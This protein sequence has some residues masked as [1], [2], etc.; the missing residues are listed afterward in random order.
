MTTIQF[1]KTGN[2]PYTILTVYSAK[3]Q[4]QV[5]KDLVSWSN[6]Q[7]PVAG[8]WPITISATNPSKNAFDLNNINRSF[9][10]T[11]VIDDSSTSGSTVQHARDTLINMI[12]GGGNCNFSYGISGDATSSGYSPSA[13]NIYF[14]STGF[15]GYITRIM[16]DEVPKGGSSKYSAGTGPDKK[17]PE[18]YEVTI[19]FTQAIEISQ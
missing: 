3:V 16:I 4:E 6:I 7:L 11:G 19:T 10:I 9:T 12:R 14:Y 15:V 17:M 8:T 1:T 5:D 2:V 18:L 13:A